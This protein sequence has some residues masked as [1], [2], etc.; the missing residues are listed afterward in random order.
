MPSEKRYASCRVGDLLV[1][2]AVDAVQ[3]VTAGVELTPVPLA[4]SVVSGLMNLR[5]RIVTAI[6]LRR[7][8]HLADRPADQPPIN[9]IL[10]ADGGSIGLLVDAVG[11]VLDVDEDDFE[12]PPGTLRGQLRELVTGAY[13]LDRGLLLVLNTERVVEES[14][15]E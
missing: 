4:P 7:S 12:P 15:A 3:E 1:G 5:G 14:N 11:D 6:D 13:K 2:V 8:L 9:L 10:R